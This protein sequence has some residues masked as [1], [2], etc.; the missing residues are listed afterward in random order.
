MATLSKEYQHQ[1]YLKNKGK[2][3]AYSKK[4][5][6]LHREQHNAITR[7]WYRK[8]KEKC[9]ERCKAWWAK[10][11]DKRRDYWYKRH[12]GVSYNYYKMLE[13]SQNN[14]CAICKQSEQFYKTLCL[15]HDHETLKNRG[16]LCHKCNS[17]L[18]M[19]HDSVWIL[20]SM[21]KYI[22]EH[23]NGQL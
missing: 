19:V 10:N 14:K 11:S 16:L 23:K 12:Y 4:W 21:I 8:N 5:R 22:K 9:Q 15:D 18:G 3:L 17:A 7:A 6:I 2:K 20:E 13:A 1:W